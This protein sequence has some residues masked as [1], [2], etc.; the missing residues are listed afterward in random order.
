MNTQKYS[1]ALP[2]AK[3]Q[4]CVPPN[5]HISLTSTHTHLWQV[6][7]RAISRRPFGERNLHLCGGV[8]IYV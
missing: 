8:K 5:F 2:V 4:S 7:C 3:R 1:C 6:K